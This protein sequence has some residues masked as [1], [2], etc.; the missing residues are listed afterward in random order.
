MDVS[1]SHSLTDWCSRM[2]S[3]KLLDSSV[4]V[5]EVHSPPT[6]TPR[7]SR[8]SVKGPL[9]VGAPPLSFSV[10]VYSAPVSA[11]LSRCLCVQTLYFLNFAFWFTFNSLF[12]VLYP[13]T[14]SL[15]DQAGYDCERLGVAL[16]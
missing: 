15:V 5:F 14:E 4:D 12:A 6:D 16:Q 2:S 13:Y 7:S 10:F 11:S 8:R 9:W 1:L 3:V